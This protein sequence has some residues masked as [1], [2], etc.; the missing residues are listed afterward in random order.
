MDKKQMKAA[1]KELLQFAP[2]V[3]RLFRDVGKDP[4]VPRRVK[5]D[6]AAAAAYVVMPFDVIP[7]F[8]P[9]FGRLDDLAV[10]GWAVRRLLMGAGEPIVREHWKGTDRG[11]ELLMQ[12]A[13]AG[14]RPHRLLAALAYGT[15]TT[16]EPKDV[17]DGEV[18][19]EK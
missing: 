5:W 17:I 6:A 13:A 9:G 16:K 10:I 4:R 18:L 12:V 1:G 11:L 14:M 7:D 2:D 19:A 8:I 3:A 15:L